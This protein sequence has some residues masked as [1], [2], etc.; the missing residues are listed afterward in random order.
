[1]SEREEVIFKVLVLGEMNTGKTS[2]IRRY[3]ERKFTRNYKPTMGADFNQK[4]FFQNDKMSVRMQLWDIAGQERFGSFTR[5][6]YKD[7]VSAIVVFDLDCPKTLQTAIKWKQDID[8]KVTLSDGSPLPVILVGNKNDL[9]QE[10][11]WAHSLYSKQYFSSFC[12]DYG[13]SAWFT[14]SCLDGSNID[15]PFQFIGDM[16]IKHQ[17]PMPNNKKDTIRISSDPIK[18]IRKPCCSHS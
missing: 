2:L 8:D 9:I 7:A 18:S 15:A 6:Y 11:E 17:I 13:F 1:M 10:K 3:V 4:D 5:V 14:T 12:K 16:V